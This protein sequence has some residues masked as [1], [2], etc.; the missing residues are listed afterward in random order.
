MKKKIFSLTLAFS[1]FFGIASNAFAAAKITPADQ[2]ILGTH[3]TASWTLSWSGGPSGWYMVYFKP[4]SKYDYKI[5]DYST[6]LTSKRHSEQYLIRENAAFHYPQLKVVDLEDPGMV[7]GVAQ[8]RV[9][10]KAY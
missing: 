6:T 2:T 7:V 9:Y 1:L 8:A 3:T 5:I 10:Q 4:D